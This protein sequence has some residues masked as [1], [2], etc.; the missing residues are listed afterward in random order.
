MHGNQLETLCCGSPGYTAP[1][2]LNREGYGLKADVFSCGI[3]MYNLYAPRR[4]AYRERRLTGIS[5]FAAQTVE[6]MIE[7]NKA[8]EIA[9]P[10]EL[11]KP[12]SAEALDL[13][14]LMTERDQYN[15]PTAKQCLEHRWFSRDFGKSDPVLTSVIENLTHSVAE[16]TLRKIKCAIIDCLSVLQRAPAPGWTCTPLPP[17]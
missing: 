12:V 6:A 13:V 3:I 15:R 2:V 4:R 17:C 14:M 11:W 8:C 1:E 7:K 9:Y 10:I 16:Y 5:P